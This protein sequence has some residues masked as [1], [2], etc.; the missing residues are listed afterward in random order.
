MAGGLEALLRPA[1]RML[2][3]LVL[4]VCLPP[5]GLTDSGTKVD[6]YER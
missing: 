6:G 3:G 2:G 1:L 4:R 5:G